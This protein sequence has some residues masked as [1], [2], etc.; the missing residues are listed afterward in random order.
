MYKLVWKDE[1]KVDGKPDENTWNLETGGWGFGNQESQ[2]YTNDLKNAYIKDGVLHIVALREDYE[3][4]NYTSAKLTTYGKKS[5]QYGKIVVKAKLP[6]GRGTWPAIWLLPDSIQKEKEP[7]PLCGE[8]DI[9]EHVGK[10]PFII[11]YSLHSEKYNH[12]INTQKTHFERIENIYDKFVNYEIRWDEQS[13]EYYVDGIKRVEYKKETNDSNK[14]WPYNKPYYLILNL[15]IGG[16]WGGKIDDSI[17]PA[18]LKISSVEVY[19][20]S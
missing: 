18:I 5:I 7:W 13:I 9:M 16:T 4:K 19:E 17:F 3:N 10:D 11:H 20:K 1:F 2:Y 8:I 15:A 12:K 6:K 14:E